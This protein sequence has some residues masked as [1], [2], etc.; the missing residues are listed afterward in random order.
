MHFWLQISPP[1]PTPITCFFSQTCQCP[2]SK[3]WELITGLGVCA[4][5]AS[6][7]KSRGWLPEVKVLDVPGIQLPLSDTVVNETKLKCF[8][9]EHNT[10]GLAM[11]ELDLLDLSMYMYVVITA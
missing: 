6:I 1:P 2:C 7:I 4:S 8:V 9:Q 3:A 10:M 5:H 11:F